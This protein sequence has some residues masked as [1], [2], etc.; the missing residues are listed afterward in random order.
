[1]ESAKDRNVIVSNFVTCVEP[2]TIKEYI[3][4]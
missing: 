1:M 4:R 2:E 3:V